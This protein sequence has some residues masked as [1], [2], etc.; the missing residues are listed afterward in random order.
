MVCSHAP[1]LGTRARRLAGSVDCHL[2][3]RKLVFVGEAKRADLRSDARG[4]AH[5]GGRSSA[6]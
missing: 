3:R 4:D 2:R 6:V 1:V 5:A